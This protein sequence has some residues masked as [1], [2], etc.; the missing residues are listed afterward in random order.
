ML[1]YNYITF[2]PMNKMPTPPR[3]FSTIQIKC[4]D[5]TTRPLSVL[6]FIPA[7]L[8]PGLAVFLSVHP[9]PKNRAAQTLFLDM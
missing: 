1:I 7:I 9:Q 3:R 2:S 5:C 8:K 6:I 4:P